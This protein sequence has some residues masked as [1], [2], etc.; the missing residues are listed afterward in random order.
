MKDSLALT[1]FAGVSVFV[2]GQ[3]FLKLVLDPIVEMKSTL[4]KLSALFLREQAKITN[5]RASEETQREIKK[6]SSE[7]LAKRQAIPSYKYMS[8]IFGL[9]S[10]ENILAS[11]KSLNAIAHYVIEDAPEIQSKQNRPIEIYKEMQ[12]IQESLGVVI[13]YQTL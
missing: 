3:F 2:L 11:C 6:M 12:S 10:S 8:Y 7:L 5:A 1:I 13:A 4:G 9:P